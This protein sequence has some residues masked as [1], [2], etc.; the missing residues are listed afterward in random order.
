M[1]KEGKQLREHRVGHVVRKHGYR[2]RVQLFAKVTR[3][4]DNNVVVYKISGFAN[5]DEKTIRVDSSRLTDTSLEM[6]ESEWKRL[7]VPP[8]PTTRKTTTNMDLIRSIEILPPHNPSALDKVDQDLPIEK[9]DPFVSL[10]A[11]LKQEIRKSH[12]AL[13]DSV[14]EAITHSNKKIN[15][16]ISNLEHNLRVEMLQ[17]RLS[18]ILSQPQLSREKGQN[19][20]VE[21]A[22]K[23]ENPHHGMQSNRD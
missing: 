9:H 13:Q 3:S 8:L 12:L 4:I 23:L 2:D 1:V 21:S 11:S 16:R 20:D 15:N 7:W 22:A 14:N 5:Q 18:Q 10:K 6:F 17:Q 19:L